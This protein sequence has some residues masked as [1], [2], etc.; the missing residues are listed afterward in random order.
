MPPRQV[1]LITGCS[2]GIGRAAAVEASA[3]GHHVFATAR[4]PATLA[5]LESPGKLRPLA[6][7]VTDAASIAAAVKS[8]TEEAGRLDALVNNAGFGQ[9]G[10]V[11]E[12]SVDEW[13]AQYDVNVFGAIA[14]IRAVLPAMRQGGGGTIVNVSSVAGRI[15][16]PFAAPYCSS[17]HALEAISDALRVE[18]APFGVRVVVVQS[19][20]IESAFGRRARGSV[21]P[22]LRKPGPYADLYV[23]AER[24]MT[25]DF[26]S[27]MLPARSVARVIV[28]AIESRRPRTRYKVTRMAKTLIPLKRF[29][30]DRLLDRGM[31]RS[32]G[33]GPG[34]PPRTS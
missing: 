7:D 18:V 6:L 22:L 29:L 23:G 12:V 17:K 26:A 2:S 32:L 10:A 28:R 14:M 20:P 24:A 11:E 3:R 5:G 16:I 19:G 21:E 31:R 8:V 34:K 15:S 13:R 9:Y 33:I 4:D 27:G 25:G 30:P 1:V